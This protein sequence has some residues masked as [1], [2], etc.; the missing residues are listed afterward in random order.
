MVD[1]YSGSPFSKSIAKEL[2]LTLLYFGIDINYLNSNG[3][4]PLMESIKEKKQGL[5]KFLLSGCVPSIDLNVRA[6]NNI[7]HNATALHFTIIQNDYEGLRHFLEY[8]GKFKA[9]IGLKD[10]SGRNA[11]DLAMSLSY[12]KMVDML[13]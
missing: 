7:F 10:N 13:Q 6:R 1:F 4:T 11:V 3:L 5:T 8:K 2:L 12:Q 9:E